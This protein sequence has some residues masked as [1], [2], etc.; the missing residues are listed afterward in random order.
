MVEK[1][2]CLIIGSGPAGYTAGIYASRSGLNPVIYE[3]MQPGGQLTIT[4]EVENFPGYPEGESG[5]AIVED[6]RKQ[7]IRMGAEIRFGEITEVD[8]SKQPF[9]LVVD[10]DTEVFAE[11]V[12]IATGAT[13]RWLGLESEAQFRGFGVSTCATCDGA[14]FK[15]KTVAVIG[16]G[17]TALEEAHYLSK[18]A[19][20]V[21]LV[22]RREQFR[23]SK[24]M[25]DRIYKTPNI[26]PVL[27]AI[28]I[29]VLG[30]KQGFTRQVTGLRIQ[31][32]KT[33]AITDIALDGI[34]VAVGVTPVTDLFV[35]QLDLDD[36]GYIKTQGV[37]PLTNVPG[38]FAAGDVQ[39]P[40]YRQACTAAASG[41]KAAIEAERFLA[42]I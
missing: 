8:F 39:D 17:D 36:Q 22:H 28:P 15:G 2:K 11:T 41:C 10:Y 7:A 5:P 35:G 19:A 30:E 21:Y 20:K 34:F 23:A 13:A 1:C 40:Y 27:D 6:I 33:E 42:E 32:K 29:D 3:G 38:I 25:Q 24:T 9:R 4:S 26:E 31:N 18:I 16:G 14:F 12:I 37:R